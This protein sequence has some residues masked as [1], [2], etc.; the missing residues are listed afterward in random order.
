MANCKICG[1]PTTVGVVT[2]APCLG[3]LL[4]AV[5]DDYCYWSKILTSQ[6][7]LEEQH[8]ATCPVVKLLEA[9]D[10]ETECDEP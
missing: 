2:H 8:C 9:L 10:T 7:V 5:C 6:Y 1:H 4:S 3:K